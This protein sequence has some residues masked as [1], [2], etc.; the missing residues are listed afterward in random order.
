MSQ[1]APSPDVAGLIEAARHLM[2]YLKWT[3]GPESCG[4]HLT[5]PSVVAAF[6]AALSCLTPPKQDDA[7][8]STVGAEPVAWR[9]MDGGGLN[10]GWRYSDRDPRC[11]VEEIERQGASCVGTC[12][13]LYTAASLASA[14]AD[15]AW[16]LIETLPNTDELIIAYCPPDP[17]FPEGRMMIWRA[18]MLFDQFARIAKGIKQPAHLSYPATHW[19]PL[20]Q[21]PAAIRA[22]INKDAGGM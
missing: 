7:R 2:P 14:R 17:E 18:S 13:R 21:P 20:P 15:G 5:M 4:H 12:Q 1:D 10:S 3:I 19:R 8:D 6:E 22:L 11:D 16:Q 9:W